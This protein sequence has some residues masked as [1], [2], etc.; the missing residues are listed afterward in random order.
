MKKMFICIVISLAVLGT[1]YAYDLGDI[2]IH[3]FAST[4]YMKSTDNNFLLSSEDGSFEFNEAGINFSTALNENIRI[5]LQ[6]YSFDNG[7]IGNNDINLDWAFLDYKWKNELGVR[8]GK[9]KTPLGLYNEVRDYD[10]LRTSILMPQSVYYRYLRETSI[11]YQGGGIYGN[12]FLNRFGSLSY[13]LIYGTM[14][15]ASDGGISKFLTT[16]ERSFNSG[17]IDYVAGGRI[18]W[19]TPLKGLLFAASIYQLEIIYNM[20][21]IGAPVGI[22]IEFPEMM[23]EYYSAEYNIGNFTVAAEYTTFSGDIETSLDYS[24]LGVPSPEPTTDD[25]RDEGYYISASYGITEWFK[26]APIIPCIIPIRTIATVK[27][28]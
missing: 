24:K 1:A 8:L 19:N 5:G 22:A 20:E 16:E 14:E 4:G 17:K 25:W 9:I 10:M 3:G 15:M 11:G 27:N 26:L 12:V 18:R 6:L 23:V 21:A 7:N 28:L 2:E 13:D